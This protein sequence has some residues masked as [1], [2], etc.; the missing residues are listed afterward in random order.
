MWKSKELKKRYG[1][2][3]NRYVRF[4][5]Q[6]TWLLVSTIGSSGVQLFALR[7]SKNSLHVTRR[8][9][10][11]VRAKRTKARASP[12]C[13]SMS[14]DTASGDLWHST[15]GKQRE[16]MTTQFRCTSQSALG[17]EVKERLQEC[18]GRSGE[19]YSCRGSERAI[20]QC[21]CTSVSVSSSWCWK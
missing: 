14:A 19:A 18:T 1:Q 2:A 3:N 6:L 11:F 13:V 4:G 12:L 8:I 17:Y 15:D 5:S 21:R 10:Q 7:R 16:S 20:G 9:R